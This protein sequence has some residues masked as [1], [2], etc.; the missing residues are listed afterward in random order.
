MLPVIARR[1]MTQSLWTLSEKWKTFCVAVGFFRR[2]K[3]KEECKIAQRPLRKCESK[4]V[5]KRHDCL[6][7]F[8]YRDLHVRS[9]LAMEL[10]GNFVITDDLDGIGQRDLALVDVIALRFERCGDV[11]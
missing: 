5:R 6:L 11:R 7:F 10:Y 2:E 9:D 4:S 3:W 1:S 8:S